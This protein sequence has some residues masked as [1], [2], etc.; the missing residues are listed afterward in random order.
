MYLSNLSID[1]MLLTMKLY[2]YSKCVGLLEP[3]KGKMHSERR[4]PD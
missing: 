3:V 2:L 1:K 4:E